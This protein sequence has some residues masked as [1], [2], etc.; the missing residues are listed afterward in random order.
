MGKWP[1]TGGQWPVGRRS[2]S[3]GKVASDQR[4][5]VSR[6]AE[7][8]QEESGGVGWTRPPLPHGV[9]KILK[10]HSLRGWCASVENVRVSGLGK[11]LNWQGLAVR[12][13]GREFVI[14]N[15]IIMVVAVEDGHD[16]V[17]FAAA[18]FGERFASGEAA[19]LEHEGASLAD[20]AGVPGGENAVGDGG[21][22][23]GE[24]AVDMCV[25]DRA[26]G[27]GFQFADE[28]GG[29]KPAA[30]R[31]GM[32]VAESVGSRVGGEGASASIGESKLAT[33]VCGFGLFRSH[34]GRVSLCKYTCLVTG[35]YVL[36]RMAVVSVRTGSR[37]KVGN[38]NQRLVIRK[39]GRRSGKPK[40]H[41]CMNQPARMG[42][43]GPPNQ[44]PYCCFSGS[45][46]IVS[47]IKTAGTIT[48]KSKGCPKCP[49]IA[50]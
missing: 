10:T 28:I 46:F 25:V 39:R 16:E 13:K 49:G 22:E 45:I 30:R 4:P 35:G 17:P 12:G 36:F 26:A 31:V 40:T 19:A 43:P 20:D 21:G 27:G 2:R 33:S 3:E 14:G 42:H 44:S 34:A 41:P 6:E 37:A 7:P 11:A 8:F 50:E 48:P 47:T 5:V 1:A 18:G 29:A 23:F 38:S 15:F 9:G 32:G 24:Q